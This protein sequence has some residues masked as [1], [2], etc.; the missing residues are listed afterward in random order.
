VNLVT[1]T[2]GASLDGAEAAA[3]LRW[4]TP[5]GAM[6]NAWWEPLGFAL[7]ATRPGAQ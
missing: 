5:A 1:V 7:P 6:V 3:E 2:A 4:F